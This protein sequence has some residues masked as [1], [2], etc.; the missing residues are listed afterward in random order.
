[1]IVRLPHYIRTYVCY[2]RELLVNLADPT[3]AVA[4]LALLIPQEVDDLVKARQ[5]GTYIND[6]ATQFHISRMTVMAHL[7]RRGL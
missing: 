4:P 7:R 2:I 6:L 1:M 5:A 3:T